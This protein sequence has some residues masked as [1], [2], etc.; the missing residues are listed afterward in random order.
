MTLDKPQ[1]LRLTFDHSAEVTRIGVPSLHLSNIWQI[2]LQLH[3]KAS[4][5]MGTNMYICKWFMSHDQNGDHTL[6]W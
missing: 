5:G 3:I 2:E 4:S 1:R 6:I